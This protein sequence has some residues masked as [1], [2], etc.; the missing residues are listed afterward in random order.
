LQL[1][2]PGP[3]RRKVVGVDSWAVTGV[4]LCLVLASCHPVSGSPPDAEA[5]DAALSDSACWNAARFTDAGTPCCSDTVVVSSGTC[6]VCS[7]PTCTGCAGERPGVNCEPSQPDGGVY[8]HCIKDGDV[9]E[10]KVLGAYCCNRIVDSEKLRGHI[11]SDAPADAGADGHGCA[12]VYPP[13]VLVCSACGDA[14]CAG[15]ENRCN[16][17]EDCL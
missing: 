6:S 5:A 8:G 1:V 14:Q 2:V 9:F 7:S 3:T 10:A 16:C 4:A 13:S 11:S 12:P 15:W 17:P